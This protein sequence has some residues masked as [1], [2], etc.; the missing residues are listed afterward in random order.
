MSTSIRGE[1]LRKLAAKLDAH[2]AA[3]FD[4]SKEIR[5]AAGSD[6]KNDELER[7]FFLSNIADQVYRAAV[8]CDTAAG[9]LWDGDRNTSCSHGDWLEK[10][11]EVPN[12]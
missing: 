11:E 6:W 2:R 7:D 3:L 12:E 8:A 4:I 9:D 1:K 5:N 10:A